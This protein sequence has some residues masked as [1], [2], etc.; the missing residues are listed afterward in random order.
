MHICLTHWNNRRV[1]VTGFQQHHCDFDNH[2][3]AIVHWHC[4]LHKKMSHLII[5]FMCFLVA[6]LQWNTRI[7]YKFRNNHR[8]YRNRMCTGAFGARPLWIRPCISA[9]DGSTRI[10]ILQGTWSG[11]LHQTELLTD[12]TWVILTCSWVL[13]SDGFCIRWVP[14]LVFELR[15]RLSVY[16]DGWLLAIQ[17]EWSAQKRKRGL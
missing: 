12:A 8:T 14:Y 11:W 2:N 16:P 13:R 5:Y 10:T 9:Y 3:L 17:P 15:W 7:W 6:G 4:F 1:P